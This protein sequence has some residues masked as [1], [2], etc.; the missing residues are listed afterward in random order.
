MRETNSPTRGRET[1][2]HLA[3]RTLRPPAGDS[4]SET[5]EEEEAEVEA[6]AEAEEEDGEEEG[7][8]VPFAEMRSRLKASRSWSVDTAAGAARLNSGDSWCRAGVRVCVRNV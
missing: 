7:E 3:V 4:V 2:L 6:E 5:D 8:A 1:L